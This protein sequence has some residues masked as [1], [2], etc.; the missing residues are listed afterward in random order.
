MTDTANLNNGL[1]E[2]DKQELFSSPH[3][4][5]IESLVLKG[6]AACRERADHGET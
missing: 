3:R 4:L 5:L 6:L 1:S 2:A